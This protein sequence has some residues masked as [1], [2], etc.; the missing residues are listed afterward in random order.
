[1]TSLN[2]TLVRKLSHVEAR[3]SGST[4]PLHTDSALKTSIGILNRLYRIEIEGIGSRRHKHSQ[5]DREFTS[6]YRIV[7]CNLLQKED[8]IFGFLPSL[9]IKLLA[10]LGQVIA[11]PLE[12]W[13]K[14]R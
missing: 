3:T 2:R 13:K 7:F 5:E 14:D 12:L 8:R 4:P 1:M 9:Y 10:V 6:L 11:S